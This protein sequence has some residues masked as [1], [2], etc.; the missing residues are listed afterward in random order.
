LFPK[1]EQGSATHDD[2]HDIDTRDIDRSK[3]THATTT[4]QQESDNHYRN[5]HA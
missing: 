2:T 4:S 1:L 5:S 3:H